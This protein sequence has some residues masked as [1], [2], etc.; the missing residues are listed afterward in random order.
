V[1]SRHRSRRSAAHAPGADRGRELQEQGPRLGRPERRRR[2]RSHRGER[3]HGPVRLARLA[4]SL[5]A[6][7]DQ[8]VPER[9]RAAQRG[10]LRGHHH[11]RGPD[12][13]HVH[14]HAHAGGRDDVLH[15]AGP[16]REVRVGRGRDGDRH[17][18]CDRLPV[19]A[20]ARRGRR[21]RA[22]GLR[23]NPGDRSAACRRCHGPR[24]SRHGDDLP[25]AV[26]VHRNDDH[27]DAIDRLRVLHPQHRALKPVRHQDLLLRDEG[28]RH[29]R[30]RRRVVP[31]EHDAV[32]RTRTTPRPTRTRPRSEP[33]FTTTRAAPPALA[34]ITRRRSPTRT[35]TTRS[36]ITASRPGP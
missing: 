34:R 12:G 17:D 1:V 18:V 15:A 14:R 4:E 11:D 22:V 23:R 2:D 26:S 28:R 35:P 5:P 9:V 13:R 6:A 30:L 7:G 21:T 3:R 33:S 8:E 16:G 36:S 31:G 32:R 27:G 20:H 25:A 24:P 29:R 19:R 10:H